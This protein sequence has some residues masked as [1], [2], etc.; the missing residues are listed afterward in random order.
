M[1]R[2]YRISVNGKSYD[3]VVEELGAAATAASAPAPVPVAATAAAAPVA[4]PAPAPVPAPAPAAEAPKAPI[5]GG[6]TITS[7]MP[8]KIWKLHVREGDSIAE[9]QLA[10]VLEAM[11]MENEIFS[12]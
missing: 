8:G 1:A 5:A 11:K 10:L 7:P 12:P 3:V 2:S 6:T 4:A 9:G